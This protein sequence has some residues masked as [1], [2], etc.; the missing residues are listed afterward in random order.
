MHTPEWTALL[1]DL[2][3]TALHPL[4]AIAQAT[5]RRSSSLESQAWTGIL[6]RFLEEEP[7]DDGIRNALLSAM[8]QFSRSP[9]SAVRHAAIEALA[10]V[11]E[12]FP[13]AR[14]RLEEIAAHDADP[15][16]R[17]TAQSAAEDLE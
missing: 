7:E 8:I 12:D 5:R 17:S 15:S 13:V 3:V 14:Q 16:I 9:D 1:E 10:R 11:A 2:I 4:R 6:A